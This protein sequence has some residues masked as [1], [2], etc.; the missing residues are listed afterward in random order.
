LDRGNSDF[1]QRH[2]LVFFFTY[3]SGPR[4]G[5]GAV[6]GFLRNW[7]ISALGAVRSGLPFTVQAL[8]NASVPNFE[9]LINQR[10][11]LMAPQQVYISQP[12]NGGRRLLNA[13]AFANPGPNVIGSSGRNAFS[14]PGLFNADASLARTFSFPSLAE[15][16]RL[17]LRAD[18][19]NFLN[20]ANLNNPESFFGAPDFGVALFGRREI[21]NGF[22]LLAPL[23]ETA[24]QAQILLRIEF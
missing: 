4:P 8:F 18:F 21:N 12:V 14:G 3:Q 5:A 10:A 6:A 13:S 1:D 20:H 9:T 19:F 7:T 2:N 17:T 16:L 11:D 23:N 24:R 15:S 22:P